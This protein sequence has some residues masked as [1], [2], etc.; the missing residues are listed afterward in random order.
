MRKVRL[1][2]IIIS[3]VL[4]IGSLLIADYED[5]ISRPNLASLLIIIVSVL[6]ILSMVLSIRNENKNYPDLPNSNK[7]TES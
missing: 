2:I 6:N 4:I 1:S 5:L 7:N 3:I